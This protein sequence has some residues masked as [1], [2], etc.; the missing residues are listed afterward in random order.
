MHCMQKY[1]S[2]LY[3]FKD[4]LLSNKLDSTLKKKNLLQHQSTF[5]FLIKQ[6]TQ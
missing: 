5:S 1:F 6:Q 2:T 3:T 4:K